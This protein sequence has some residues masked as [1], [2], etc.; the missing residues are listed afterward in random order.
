[1][2]SITVLLTA[3]SAAV[4][5]IQPG[6]A[7]AQAATLRE[8]EFG[9]LNFLHTTDTHGWHAGHL[10]ESSYSADWGD[11]VD[12]TRHLKTRLDTE[13]KDLLIIDTGDRIEGNGLYDASDPR[14]RYTFNV[15][16]QQHLDLICSG[17]H[18]LY[19]NQSAEDDFYKL[20]PAY[21]DKYLASNLDI[22]SPK[23]GK[24]TPMGNKYR[25]FTTKYQGIR[26]MAFGFLFDFDRNAANT[27]VNPVEREIQTEWFTAAV[28]RSD[29][30]LFVVIGHVGLRSFEFEKVHEV[31]RTYHEKTPIQFFGG[32]FHVRDYRI[33]DDR[34]HGLASG[35]YMETIGFQS[36]SGLSTASNT[37]RLSFFRRYIDNNLYSLYHHSSTNSSTFHSKIGGDTTK[38]IIR[39]RAALHLD[40]VYGCT[41]R[42]YWIN[43]V[44]VSSPESFFQVLI[45]NISS[46]IIQPK[47]ADK[48]RMIIHNTGAIRFDVF[49]GMF[50]VDSTYIVSPFTSELRFIPDVPLRLARRISPILNG[51]DQLVEDRLDSILFPTDN[52]LRVEDLL[53][54]QQKAIFHYNLSDK[55]LS[56]SEA[57]TPRIVYRHDQQVMKPD[58]DNSGLTL[59]PGYTTHDDLG[60]DGDDT[61]HS[62]I[63]FYNVP[64]VVQAVLR[65]QN[66]STTLETSQQITCQQSRFYSCVN[67]YPPGLVIE[68]LRPQIRDETEPVPDGDEVV[69]L[70]FNAFLQP[71]I[72]KILNIL[73]Q[74]DTENWTTSAKY[75][76]DD[77]SNYLPGETFTS[78][79]A[80]W[81]QENWPCV[82]PGA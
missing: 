54:P 64:N 82:G 68:P 74:P 39:A 9:D 20:M 12:F 60:Q 25:Y 59:T 2:K 24:F 79:F 58:P 51:G 69:D 63:Q 17:N 7:P 71:Y 73:S 42:T 10:L 67:D 78:F 46:T 53:P 11:Y 6:A 55:R 15:F 1:M 37:S 56:L 72:L 62:P 52:R 40:N 35:R 44:P 5:A 80:K 77:V 33:F 38:A 28:N 13:G 16:T 70:I 76:S 36:I 14:G 8:L 61:V 34:A 57:V 32:H 75:T 27:R 18:E 48:S 30:D 21:Q 26:I 31:I 23:T 65:A 43:R 3:V 50:T 41:P 4:Q 47:R 45:H 19:K 22:L 29:I 49:K 66:S 81:V